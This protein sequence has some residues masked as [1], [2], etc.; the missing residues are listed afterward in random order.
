MGKLRW[1]VSFRFPYLASNPF[2]GAHGPPSLNIDGLAFK[3][4]RGVINS[5]QLTLF[6][7][8]YSIDI[9]TLHG[10]FKDEII[11]PWVKQMKEAGEKAL[12]GTT[13]T[14]FK[15]AK[16]L[17]TSALVLREDRYKQELEKKEKRMERL[18]AI[19]SNLLAA[20]EASLELLVR[21]EAL[22]TR[23]GQ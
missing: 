22:E 14:R 20:E 4:T 10:R 21:L 9:D 5:Q 12:L 8:Q 13:E 19:Y 1:Y 7:R 23:S 17:M 11:D 15:A 16:N 3:E 18:V 2:L 6:N